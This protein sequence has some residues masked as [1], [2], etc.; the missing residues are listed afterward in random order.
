MFQYSRLLKNLGKPYMRGEDVRAVQRQLISLGY[1]KKGEDDGI[2]G[3]DTAAAVK[4]YQKFRRLK[5]DGIVGAITWGSLFPAQIAPAAESIQDKLCAHAALRVAQGSIYVLG[6]QGQS[7]TALNEPW[8]RMR[9]HNKSANI[10][11]V[12]KLWN[13]RKAAGYTD[14]HADD[15]SGLIM[16]LLIREGYA[17]K[18]ANADGIYLRLCDAIDRTELRAGDVVGKSGHIGIYMGDGTVIHAK[19]RDVGVVRESINAVRWTR[20]GR[21]KA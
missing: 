13:A 3:P 12:L 14:I 7:G 11:R 10:K 19:G 20:Y 6:A 8:I 9:E 17:E 5:R 15:C 1:L 16:E 2:Y 21:L 18:D 4:A